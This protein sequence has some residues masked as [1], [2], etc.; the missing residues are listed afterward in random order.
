M[1]DRV[2]P[3]EYSI[4]R[5]EPVGAFVD[6]LLNVRLE[7]AVLSTMASG[8]RVESLE[9]HHFTSLVRQKLYLLMRSGVVFEDLDDHLLK[10]GMGPELGY[11]AD[12]FVTSLLPHIA[13][14]EAIAELK[15]LHLMRRFCEDVDSWRRSAPGLD[16]PVAIRRLGEVIRR[17]GE[18]AAR[19]LRQANPRIRTQKSNGSRDTTPK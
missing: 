2:I 11:V 18:A 7:E 14:K 9:P 3:A 12:L 1:N 17:Q 13:L 4:V 15:R 5:S 8:R 19:E 6:P 10:D 16:W